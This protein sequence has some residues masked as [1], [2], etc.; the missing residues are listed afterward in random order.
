ML[1]HTKINKLLLAILI[2]INS[3][4]F[5]QNGNNF[6]HPDTAK[7]DLSIGIENCNFVW[8]NEYFNPIV[9]G[10]TLIGYFFTPSI[11]YQF[12]PNLSAKGGVHLLKY[13][14]VDK[15][16]K[17]LPVYSVTYSKS[18]FSLTLGT[19]N[20]TINHRL[21][22][23]MFLA[24]R[25]FTNNIENGL[26]TTLNKD[27]LFIDIWVD[28]RNFIFKNDNEQEL[29]TA[30]FSSEVYPIKTD[31]WELSVP[32]SVLLEHR[33][34]QID[35]A[36]ANMKTAMNYSGGLQLAYKTPTHFI[37]KINISSQYHGFKD[38][39][40]TVESIFTKGSGLLTELG[41]FNKQSFIKI[42]YWKANKYLSMLG[43]PIFQCFSDKGAEKHTETRELFTTK[44]YWNYPIYNGIY[45]AFTG[46]TFYDLKTS[47]FDFTTGL[48]LVINYNKYFSKKL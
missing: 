22:S 33:G 24:E 28:W 29:L 14:G 41:I 7:S 38:N 39:S 20:G 40:P 16:T 11:K 9:E 43:H 25:Y 44:L 47:D 19:L 23:P 35:T 1:N 30:G 45:L 21:S 18:D 36:S 26:Q 12:S 34:G 5:A 10:Y 42:G 27:K 8:N 46:E 6:T 31:A 37:S 32:I 3:Y 4:V 48:T 13:S 17:V 2:L 15:F